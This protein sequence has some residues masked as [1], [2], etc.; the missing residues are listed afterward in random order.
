MAEQ[1]SNKLGARDALIALY[2]LLEARKSK[3]N[4]V[5][6]TDSNIR[7]VQRLSPLATPMPGPLPQGQTL[8]LG[9]YLR[10]GGR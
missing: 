1:P 5:V 4:A 2:T 3:G 10:G 8:P 7:G 9:A 6:N